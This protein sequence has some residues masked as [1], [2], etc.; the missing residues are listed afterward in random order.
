MLLQPQAR[1]EQ[2]NCITG[3][4]C[5]YRMI[6]WLSSPA[7]IAYTKAGFSVTHTLFLCDIGWNRDKF[8]RGPVSYRFDWGCRWIQI[9]TLYSVHTQPT[10]VM[11]LL[12]HPISIWCK[13]SRQ[14]GFRSRPVLGRLRLLRTY[15]AFLHI[16]WSVKTCLTLVYIVA[17]LYFSLEKISKEIV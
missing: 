12:R 15:I 17:S 14:S 10:C 6:F 9:R 2:V 4:S 16:F 5:Q 7:S 1:I 3:P 11:C 13:Y 8:R